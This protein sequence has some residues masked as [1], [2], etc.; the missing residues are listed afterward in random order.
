MVGCDPSTLD[1]HRNIAIH[2]TAF[3]ENIIRFETMAIEW[4]GFN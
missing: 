1:D 2:N 3:I 4:Y